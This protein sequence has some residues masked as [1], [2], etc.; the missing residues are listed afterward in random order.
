ME[1]SPLHSMQQLQML[2]TIP[3]ETN[4]KF[5]SS[6]YNGTLPQK[7]YIIIILMWIS[8][9]DFG[10]CFGT[11]PSFGPVEGFPLQFCGWYFWE[12]IM[13]LGVVLLM[14]FCLLIAQIKGLLYI[15]GKDTNWGTTM[16]RSLVVRIHP[17]TWCLDPGIT[18]PREV[19]RVSKKNFVSK[20]KKIHL[21]KS[22]TNCN[23]TS[24]D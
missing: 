1:R 5:S 9:L 10:L 16:C 12:M 17:E 23:T 8:T 24:L 4:S 7:I 2:P 11:G 6:S 22:I 15:P 18:T 20:G 21:Q 13:S 3:S 14:G 19:L